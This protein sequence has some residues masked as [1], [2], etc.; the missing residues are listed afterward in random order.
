MQGMNENALVFPN[1]SQLS[2]ATRVACHA[3]TSL[4]AVTDMELTDAYPGL[5]VSPV[6]AAA[7]R[8]APAGARAMCC[9]ERGVYWVAQHRAAVGTLNFHEACLRM[10]TKAE[11][12]AALSAAGVG[13]T[14]KYRL[15]DVRDPASLPYPLIAKPNFGFASTLVKRIPNVDS[16][17]KYQEEFAELRQRSLLTEYDGFAVGCLGADLLEVVLEPDL[18]RLTRF[19]TIPFLVRDGKLTQYFPITGLSQHRSELTDFEWTGFHTGPVRHAATAIEK[20]LS[21]LIPVLGLTGGVYEIEALYDDAEDRLFVLEFSPRVTGGSIPQLIQLAF[22][23]DL[24]FLGMLNFLGVS[25]QP[26]QVH[27]ARTLVLTIRRAE[28]P[29]DSELRGRPVLN[30]RVRWLGGSEYVDEIREADPAKLS[31]DELAGGVDR[32]I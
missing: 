26:A 17:R 4:L 11:M 27:A 20:V 10:L 25:V 18:S 22:G 9:H 13:V 3:D 30:R 31:T 7:G 8:T 21:R 16:L 1:A 24:D 32:E 15:A 2:A 19:L 5:I 12:A 29:V 14:R 23:V 6:S 28:S